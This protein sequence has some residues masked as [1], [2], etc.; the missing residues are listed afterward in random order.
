MLSRSKNLTILSKL[1][2]YIRIEKIQNT[3]ESTIFCVLTGWSDKYNKALP[4]FYK[5]PYSS[6]SN[7]RELETFLKAIQ[8]RVINMSVTNRLVDKERIKFEKYL[9]QTYE[10]RERLATNAEFLSSIQGGMSLNQLQGFQERKNQLNNQTK[11]Q[12]QMGKAC[13]ERGKI[14]GEEDKTLNE[15]FD[16]KNTKLNKRRFEDMTMHLNHSKNRV[17]GAKI[18][19]KKELSFDEDDLQLI[20]N[21]KEKGKEKEES[22]EEEFK[23][24]GL[25]LGSETE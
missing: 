7:Y 3:E 11:K 17:K 19:Q 14:I 20:K 18:I 1:S 24:E 8:P 5:I 6:H 22:K 12:F 21:V 10:K 4:H 15:R 13:F 23:E 16:Q 2:N 9:K 25:Q